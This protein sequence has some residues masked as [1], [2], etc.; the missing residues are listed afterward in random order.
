MKNIIILFL[1]TALISTSQLKAQN[2]DLPKNPKVGKCYA[3]SFDYNKKFEWKEIDCS[4]V[5]GIKTARTKDQQIKKEQRRLKLVAYQKELISLDY[6]VEVN[7]ILDKK[8]IKAHN[9]LIKKKRKEEKRK[10][11][12]KKSKSK[13]E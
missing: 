3:N 7:G 11:R 5:Q 10:L 2:L 6:D 13:S 4:K 9:K 1:I 8:T 12:A